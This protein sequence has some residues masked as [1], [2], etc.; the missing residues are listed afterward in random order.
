MPGRAFLGVCTWEGNRVV[1]TSSSPRLGWVRAVAVMVLR[2]GRH[3][4]LS[5]DLIR[6]HIEV[7]FFVP[8]CFNSGLSSRYVLLHMV[9]RTL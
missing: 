7:E 6:D 2:R 4:A 3:R 5:G 8:G 1:H 9:P